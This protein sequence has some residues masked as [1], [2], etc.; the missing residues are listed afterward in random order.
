MKSNLTVADVWAGLAGT[1]VASAIPGA[2]S[3]TF[4]RG[5]IDSREARPGDLFF[6]LQGERVDGHDYVAA[7]IA[8]GASGAVVGRPVEAPEG[9]AM[10]IVSDP[11]NALQRLAANWRSRHETRVIAVTGSVG[12]TTAKELIAR[13]LSRRY[14]T[15]KSEANLNTEIGI[16]L[17]LLNLRA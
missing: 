3:R 4:E 7:A 12:K 11:L 15:L 13:V 1:L 5:L 8:A 14:R 9:A 6:A 10:F 17:T 16:P 2:A